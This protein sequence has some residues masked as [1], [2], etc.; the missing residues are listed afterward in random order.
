MTAL[1][2][3]L[4][5]P[6][7]FITI[8][9]LNILVIKKRKGNPTEQEE[10]SQKETRNRTAEGEINSN[11]E[12]KNMDETQPLRPGKE[13]EAIARHVVFA[14]D[15]MAAVRKYLEVWNSLDR[16]DWQD[17]K[18][19]RKAVYGL[20]EAL[21]N[22]P[23]GE[24]EDSMEMVVVNLVLKTQSTS[25]GLWLFPRRQICRLGS[26]NLKDK[27]SCIMFSNLV[28]SYLF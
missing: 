21:G 16:K 22:G 4:E 23:K 24:N 8:T 26:Y 13:V 17:W 1:S 7:Q 10:R 6:A 5:H 25:R 15:R 28:F 27:T 3:F 2:L 19:Y 20:N 12:N 14:E 9:K 11:L 18:K